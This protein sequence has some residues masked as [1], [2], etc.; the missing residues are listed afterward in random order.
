VWGA[1]E[2]GRVINVASTLLPARRVL[3]PVYLDGDMQHAGLQFRASNEVATDTEQLT[4]FIFP[5]VEGDPPGFVQLKYPDDSV[6]GKDP[7]WVCMLFTVEGK[8]FGILYM[9][10]PRSKHPAEFSIRYYGRFGEFFPY[11]LAPGERLHMHYRLFI[12]EGERD[13]EYLEAVY[14]GFA[15][16][17]EAEV[18]KAEWKRTNSSTTK[19][20]KT[21]LIDPEGILLTKKRIAENDPEPEKPLEALRAEADD[22]LKQKPVSVMN[23]EAV[24]PSG[25]KHDYMSMGSYW[26][27]NPDTPDGL[28]YIRKDGYGNPEGNQLDR[29]RLRKMCSAVNTLALAYYLTNHEP[30]AEHAVTLLR[31]WFLD[32]ETK[33]N[34]HLEYAQAIPG[35]CE[36][37]GIGI[38]DTAHSFAELV[39]SVGLLE[40]S[41]AWTDADREAFEEWFRTFLTWLLESDKGKDEGRQP[42]NHGTWYDVQAAAIALFLGEPAT[43]RR[44]LEAAPQRRI[45]AQIEPDG[46]QPWELRR[47]KSFGYSTMNLTGFFEVATLGDRIG[48]DLWRYETEDGRGIRKALDYLLQYVD[49]P[50]AWPHQEIQGLNWSRY[51]MLLRR[52]S[53]AY[54]DSRYEEMIEALPSM[55][56]GADRFQLLYPKMAGDIPV[57]R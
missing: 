8:R 57:Q 23:K 27:P 4:E 13:P 45:A 53:L 55:D 37:R 56:A 5:S 29:P 31:I 10:H 28:P 46:R 24:P 19:T 44:V 47:T 1:A 40:E 21:F 32:P 26:W 33:M 7:K 39:D 14:Q 18:T 51:P 12:F 41:D 30:Y 42:N 20:P 9:C 25:D 34:P 6:M 52:A 50:E 48:V 16:P 22:A 35:I 11:T 38:I 2:G 15:H 36:G 54:P 17:P 49:Q 3:E 43:A